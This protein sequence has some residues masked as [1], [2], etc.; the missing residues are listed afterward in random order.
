M[1]IERKS[2]AVERV[3]SRLPDRARTVLETELSPTDLQTLL[4][5]LARTRARRTTPSQTLRRW[6]SDRFVQP[7]RV[8]PGRLSELQS[9]LWELL[10]HTEFEGLELSPLTPLGSCASVADVDQN[11]VV[12][13]RTNK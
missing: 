2:A 10:R 5:D 6:Q 4:L 12:T 9:R 3:W 7:A 11:R 1:A 13:H 8:D